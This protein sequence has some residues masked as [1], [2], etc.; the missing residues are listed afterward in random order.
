MAIR[1][2]RLELVEPPPAVEREEL[3]VRRWPGSSAHAGS[4][5]R[6]PASR[7]VAERVGHA[8]WLELPRRL[9]ERQHPE[10]ARAD[11]LPNR[12]VD[13]LVRQIDAASRR[14]AAALSQ[15]REDGPLV[16]A[17]LDGARQLREGEDRHFEVAREHL[18][19]ARD[20]RD[21]LHPVLGVRAG[22]HQLQVVDDDHPELGLARL[23][24]ASLRAQLHHRDRA[25]V[26]DV[27]RRLHQLVAGGR[28]PRPVVLCEPARAEALRLDLGLAAH[29]PLRH[30]GLGHL[31]RE[32][33]DRC[34]VANGEVRRRAERERRLPHRR[35]GRDDDEVA[36]LEAGRE[37][38]E[39]AEPGGDAGDVDARLVEVHD[40]REA[41]VE[42]VVDVGEVAA[43]ALLGELEHHLLGAVD[44][45]GRL[46]GAC[47]AEAL[48]L[49]ADPHEAAQRRHLLDDPRVVLGVRGS[50]HDGGE[51]CDLG[52]AAD[53]L[54]LAALVELVRERDR[55]D[56]L[57]LAVEGEGGPVDRA[58]RLAV[59][60]TGLEHLGDGA[61]RRG[62][63]QHGAENR[64]LGLQ[65]L[66]RHDRGRARGDGHGR[67]QPVPKRHG[68]T[69][70]NPAPVQGKEN[71]CSHSIPRAGWLLP[72]REAGLSTANLRC[73]RETWRTL[74][75]RC[76][77]FR[78]SGGSRREPPERGTYASGA[79]SGSTASSA[80]TAS[81]TSATATAVLGLDDL[82]VGDDGLR[83]LELVDVL[84]L[85]LRGRGRGG[86]RGGFGGGRR[87]GS[88]HRGELFLGR[89]LAALGHDHQLDLGG[90]ALEDVDRDRVA[91]DPLDVV[92][93]DL[94][95]VDADLADPPDL[96]GDVGRRDRAEQRSGRAGLDVEAEH[97]LAER[98]R[99]LGSLLGAA[100]LVH[101]LLGVDALDLLDPPFR[102]H[103]G[104]VA[105]QQ[106]VAGVPAGDVHDLAAQAE[107]LHVLE[108]DHVHRIL[109][110][111]DVG[112]ERDLAGPLDR[113][114][115]LPLVAA[116]RAG[117]AAVADLA[118]LGDVAP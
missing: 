44:E 56:R 81:T 83:D 15:V 3:V 89:Q 90:D 86:C 93:A 112:Q 29:Q 71:M 40:P 80:S 39:L 28:E 95:A 58:V 79:P 82:R 107:L 69:R 42:Q 115:D 4:G 51:L 87:L 73:E 43:D 10:P 110:A 99:D 2:A 97:E 34:L 33:R 84:P 18:E 96:V 53:A 22:G 104:E 1:I 13:A 109:L 54:E 48:D 12:P 77:A 116:A 113:D 45:I 61:D 20:L 17:L 103:L 102:R 52:G 114:R 101:R 24:P 72:S 46:A 19:L 26:V 66:R 76:G 37:L 106:E 31:E 57:A 78:G 11:E 60:V 111:R 50:R 91:A 38:V 75:R 55:V 105:R 49:L 47:L 64:L 85:G 100:R 94:A 32:E 63:Q 88:L 41:L 27:D 65:V 70:R 21:L 74:H 67:S 6:R 35:P 92:D 36:G 68:K 14:K 23:E 25:R 16:V 98:R 62:R 108:Q 5:A 8:G 7:P 118:L 30:L 117:D 9:V 59:E